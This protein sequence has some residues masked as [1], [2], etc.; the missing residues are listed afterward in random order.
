MASTTVFS[1]IHSSVIFPTSLSDHS[2]ITSQI[3]LTGTP[4]RATRWRFNTMLLKNKDYCE[5][6]KNTFKEFI[7]ENI[8][9][10]EGP[11]VLWEAIKGFIRNTTISFSSFYSEQYKSE[12][13]LDK[14][15]CESFLHDLN[16]P[17]SH[18]RTLSGS[19][20]LSL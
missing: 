6:F 10:V 16:F 19:V 13:T 12:I 7:S 8:N 3:T 18:K 5:H 15:E 1:Q 17:S 20:N 9:S 2:V 4:T 11:R 14:T